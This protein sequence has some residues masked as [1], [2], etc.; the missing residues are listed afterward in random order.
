MFSSFFMKSLN[1]VLDEI[2][3]SE[4]VEIRNKLMASP[5]SLRLES[6]EPDFPVHDNI[7]IAMIRA[8]MKEYTKYTHS[9]GI[10][11]LRQEVYNKCVN[12]NRIS[13][14]SKENV[15][16][17]DGGVG[18]MSYSLHA[19]INAG[20]KE[21]VIT[22]NPT[23]TP[24]IQMIRQS[25]A[26]PVLAPLDSER[27]FALDPGE[28]EDRITRKTKA[29]ILNSPHNP[30]GSVFSKGDLEEVVEIADKNGL[31]LLSDE[32]Y[33]HIT[34]DV[35]HISPGSLSNYENIISLFT[36]SK[37]FNMTGLRLGYIATKNQEVMTNLR[38]VVLY[39][40]NGIN[41]ATQHGGVAALRDA[42]VKKDFDHIVAE[43]RKRRDILVEGINSSKHFECQSPEG[44]FYLFPKIKETE[45]SD[46]EVARKLLDSNPPLGSIQGSAFGSCG[47]GYIRLAYSTATKDVEMAAEILSRLR[48]D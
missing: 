47:G 16:I 22:H 32:A 45:L 35:E 25:G 30:T 43:Y 33:E 48:L 44:A 31:Y 23:W 10:P 27:G 41:S 20:E 19:I 24:T 3:L 18:S 40:C 4:I 6:G 17:T 2:K 26:I 42:E 14:D 37:S 34:Y 7:K 1:K 9:S 8:L 13:L 11:E 15:I 28:I 38:K 36:F 21:E 29:I 12:E 5:N 46:I 39:H